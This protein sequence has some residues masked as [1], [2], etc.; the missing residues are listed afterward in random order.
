MASTN[1]HSHTGS[2]L[3]YTLIG[4]LNKTFSFVWHESHFIPTFMTYLCL[5][6]HRRTKIMIIYRCVSKILPCSV[7]FLVY[8]NASDSIYIWPCF[9]MAECLKSHF[10][11]YPFSIHLF[12][13][14]LVRSLIRW[15]VRLFVHSFV[16]S[17]IIIIIDTRRWL[18]SNI[19]SRNSI[20]YSGFN[21]SVYVF[22]VCGIAASILHKCSTRQPTCIH[23]MD[24]KW[25]LIAWD[26]ADTTA[27]MRYVAYFRIYMSRNISNVSSWVFDA[28]LFMTKCSS[29]RRWL[30]I[31]WN[32]KRYWNCFISIVATT[33]LLMSDWT[34]ILYGSYLSSVSIALIIYSLQMHVQHTNNG[35]SSRCCL[36][37]EF[38][39][40]L[41]FF[42]NSIVEN[43]C[44]NEKSDRS[45]GSQK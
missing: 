25:F 14:S 33:R 44:D 30:C 40:G 5:S 16:H 45:N 2:L 32:R 20:A 8:C 4:K 13:H 19:A 28:M 26:I 34:P 7:L 27:Q 41:T 37:Y 10:Q 38:I 21:A 22:W 31:N 17:N 29:K 3:L 35:L 1:A 36:L 6:F 43:E 9:V 15:F 39:F 11:N 23:S 24:L 42:C 12:I 18:I